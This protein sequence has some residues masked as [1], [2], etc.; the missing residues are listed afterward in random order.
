LLGG[1]LQSLLQCLGAWHQSI[2]RSF[3]SLRHVVVSVTVR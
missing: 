1:L 3:C 2:L